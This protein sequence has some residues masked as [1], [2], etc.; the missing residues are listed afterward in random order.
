MVIQLTN[1]RNSNTN[2]AN[3]TNPSPTMLPQG[4]IGKPRHV[5]MSPMDL[6]RNAGGGGPPPLN[7]KPL[8]FNI[9]IGPQSATGGNLQPLGTPN[10][11]Q[12]PS[13]NSNDSQPPA[14]SSPQVL[15][16]SSQA[17]GKGAGGMPVAGG[18]SS[19]SSG[20]YETFDKEARDGTRPRKS[21]MRK[22][23]ASKHM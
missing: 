22:V 12:H 14:A 11:A 19:R 18:D 10:H 9:G 6:K 21:V 3:L 13:I 15:P 8:G 23:I 5:P 4:F 16:G 1:A 17:V 20:S 7:H 2:G